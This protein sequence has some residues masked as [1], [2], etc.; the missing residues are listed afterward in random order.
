MSR[1]S[2]AAIALLFFI[3]AGAQI[4]SGYYNN[5]YNPGSATPKTCA[6]LKTALYNIISSGTVELPYNSGGFDTWNALNIIDTQRN[7]ANTA[8][9]IWDMYT[10]NPT[11]TNLYTF[12]PVTD[13]C[14]SYTMIGDCYNREHSFP[15]IWF[16][17]AAPMQTDLNHLFPT[18]G[19]TNGKHDNFPYGEVKSTSVD[20]ASPAGARLGA[21][22]SAGYYGKVFEPIDAYK[23]DF[24]RA[25]FYMVTRYENLI[26]SWQGNT[27]ADSVLN[28]TTWPALDTWAIR[29]WYKWHI[30][31]PVS[32]KEINRNNKIY[33]LQKNRNPFIDHPEYV[34]LI[35]NCGTLLPVTLI[36]FTALKTTTGVDLSWKTTGENGFKE[37]VVERS[38]DG[39]S[40]EPV[41]TIKGQNLSSYK[42]SDNRIAGSINL[43]YRLKMV[44]VDGKAVNSK[45][46]AI[47]WKPAQNAISIFPNPAGNVLNISMQKPLQSNGIIRITDATGRDVAG[48]IPAAPRQSNYTI[49]TNSLAAGCYVLSV[50]SEGSIQRQQFLIVK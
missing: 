31:D 41:A 13:Q 48:R 17:S 6:T 15:Q 45:V 25:M 49:R 21:S 9:E 27:G 33:S 46:V 50:I 12:T 29:Q 24:A 30:Q 36:D 3:T 26:V 28:G 44:D 11:G 7:D 39:V 34:D 40:F 22:A 14:G 37:Y 2:F 19:F 8:Y 47:K 4:P 18:D 16:G 43:C 20:W 38:V 32:Q 1:F 42:F 35:W 10:D 23:G 5:A